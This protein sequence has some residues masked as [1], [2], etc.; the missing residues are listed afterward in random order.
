MDE[1][2]EYTEIIIKYFSSNDEKEQADLLHKINTA[3]Y[4]VLSTHF[5]KMKAFKYY[6]FDK[7]TI[8][9]KLFVKKKKK[10]NK[11]DFITKLHLVKLAKSIGKSTLPEY[12]E[13]LHNILN[14]QI[15][16]LAAFVLLKHTSNNLTFKRR[17]QLKLAIYKFNRDYDILFQENMNLKIRT[18][19]LYSHIL[20]GFKNLTMDINTPNKN[21][22][23]DVDDYLST[24][25]IYLQYIIFSIYKD[26]Y[27][28]REPI[29]QYLNNLQII[30]DN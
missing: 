4:T 15:I 20:T 26:S 18:I 16:S 30:I 11:H 8:I 19:K 14:V 3:T 7:E 1:F 25:S 27:E 23:E 22:T 29:N 24:L 17:N 2:Y 5:G 21:I 6:C 9:D 13:H 28:N 12:N 10:N